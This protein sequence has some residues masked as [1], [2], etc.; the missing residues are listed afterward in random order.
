MKLFLLRTCKILI[1]FMGSD[2]IFNDN[3]IETVYPKNT[4]QLGFTRQ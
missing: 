2:S 3:G 1:A 4:E